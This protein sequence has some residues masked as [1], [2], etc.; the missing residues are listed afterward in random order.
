MELIN[1]GNLGLITAVKRFR[2]EKIGEIKFD[3]YAIY[4]IKQ[5][6][7][8]ALNEQGSN[9]RLPANKFHDLYKIKK[10]L[11]KQSKEASNLTLEHVTKETG[12]EENDIIEI[13]NQLNVFSLDEALNVEGDGLDKIEREIDNKKLIK[14]LMLTLTDNEKFTISMY[15]GL[16]GTCFNLEEIGNFLNI[17]TTRAQ[18]IKHA[19]V[20]KLRKGLIIVSKEEKMQKTIDK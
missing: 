8:Q 3:S 16:D 10:A 7:L 6:M 12:I 13:L 5:K 20:K 18:Q 17:S 2:K 9:I 15:Y 11:M 4:W 19:A 14:K 1:E